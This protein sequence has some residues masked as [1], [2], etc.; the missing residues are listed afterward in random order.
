MFLGWITDNFL[1]LIYTPHTREHAQIS[2]AIH[3]YVGKAEVTK[4]SLSVAWMVS[5]PHMSYYSFVI[6]S[7]YVPRNVCSKLGE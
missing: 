2:L 1:W 5:I 7:F 6:F 3:T 4:R